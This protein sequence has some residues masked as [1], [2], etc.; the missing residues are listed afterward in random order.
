MYY[1]LNVPYIANRGELQRTLAFLSERYNTIALDFAIIGK[2][3][4]DTSNQIPTPLPFATPNSLRILRRCTIHLSDPSQNHRLKALSSAY[5]ILAIRPDNEKSLQQACQ[6][7][8][9]DLISL[10]LSLRYPFYFKHQ[11]MANAL[12]R[13]VKFEISYGPGILNSDGGASRRHLISN[14]T[15]LIRATRGR[16]IVISS[17]AKR[18]LACRGPADV[19]N[20]AVLWGLGQDKGMEAVGNEARSVVVQAEMKRRSFRGVI[21][22]VYG[23][24]KSERVPENSAKGKQ[25]KGKRKADVLEKNEAERVNAT[26]KPISKRE[27]KRQAKKARLDTGKNS[28]NSPK[29]TSKGSVVLA[30]GAPT[31]DC[32]NGRSK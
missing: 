18:A 29:E 12:Q 31:E 21:D 32:P 19:V 14:A 17:E 4:A 13:G 15:Q 27:Q 1:D 8:E 23:G 5:D 3:P 16:G 25:E 30:E 26:P 10:D 28:Q 2:V 22:V 24:E 7:L 6:A 9:C 20:L 11:A